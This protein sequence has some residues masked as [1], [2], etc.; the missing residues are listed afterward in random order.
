MGHLKDLNHLRS[1]RQGLLVISHAS[2]LVC[3]HQKLFAISYCRHGVQIFGYLAIF[4][5]QLEITITIT[6][7]DSLSPSPAVLYYHLPFAICHFSILLPSAI[8][9]SRHRQ[10]RRT[11]GVSLPNKLPFL[12]N[13]RFLFKK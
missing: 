3:H 7:S 10:A 2:I 12:L 8:S 5:G 9:R 1:I 11:L 4:Q 6:N 13:H